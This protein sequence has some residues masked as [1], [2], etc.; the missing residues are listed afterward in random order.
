MFT[1][2][3]VKD[4]LERMV[5]SFAGG[6]VASAAF[7]AGEVFTRDNLE[8]AVGAAVASLLLAL[9]SKQFGPNQDSA[10]IL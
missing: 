5:R 10:S 7:V 1:F 9:A 3:F 8:V 6:Y 4:V 2:K